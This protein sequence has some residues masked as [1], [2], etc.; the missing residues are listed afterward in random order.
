MELTTLVTLSSRRLP[1]LQPQ[2][3]VESN[4]ACF[5]LTGFSRSK[6]KLKPRYKKFTSSSRSLRAPKLRSSSTRDL[7]S[8]LINPTTTFWLTS[9]ELRRNLSL[10]IARSTS[11]TKTSRGANTKTSNLKLRKRAS[12]RTCN[13]FSP[14]VA[15]SSHSRRLWWAWSDTHPTK[16]LM[17]TS[18]VQCLRLSWRQPSTAQSRHLSSTQCR[19]QL[20]WSL[21]VSIAQAVVTTGADLGQRATL[22]LSSPWAP[23]W[24][25]RWPRHAPLLLPWRCS[26]PMRMILLCLPGT[27]HSRRMSGTEQ[28]TLDTA[29]Q[30]LIELK[31]ERI[32]ARVS[33]EKSQQVRNCLFQKTRKVMHQT[34]QSLLKECHSISWTTSPRR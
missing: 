5:S 27:G 24:V 14:N 20:A 22:T 2:L 16:R 23:W 29:F 19:P 28:V 6:R 17:L 8:A 15:K 10:Q 11:L 1:M 21:R 12:M 31:Y 34:C 13:A 18:F 30:Q 26:K 9:K 3:S 32:S 33:L 4:R 7:L 25:G